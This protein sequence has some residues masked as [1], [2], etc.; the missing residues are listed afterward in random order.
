M[1]IHVDI[2]LHM[3]Y[4]YAYNSTYRSPKLPLWP[5]VYMPK[6]LSVVSHYP[7]YRY[8][9]LRILCYSVSYDFIINIFVYIP[10]FYIYLFDWFVFFMWRVVFT[11]F[12]C[13]ILNTFIIL[14]FPQRLHRISTEYI[15]Y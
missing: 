12:Y 7:F 2:R 5:I 15:P 14:S 9:I 1:Y 3:I 10:C 8:P 11:D 4:D 6:A 13:N